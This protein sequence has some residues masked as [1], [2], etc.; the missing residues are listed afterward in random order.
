M[1]IRWLPKS[2]LAATLMLL[3]AGGAMSAFA[4]QHVSNPFVGAAQYANPDYAKELQALAA[5]TTDPVLKAQL[6]VITTYSTGIWMDR[7]A[8]IAG[9]SATGGRFGLQEQLDN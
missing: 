6:N 3:V 7:I 1:Q 5:T 8:A 9:S 4:Q 2:L